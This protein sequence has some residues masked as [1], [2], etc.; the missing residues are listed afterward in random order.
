VA[1]GRVGGGV[2]GFGKEV[3]IFGGAGIE[4]DEFREKGG[5]VVRGQRRL[6]QNKY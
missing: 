6:D 2:V 1:R 3:P 5:G 4:V